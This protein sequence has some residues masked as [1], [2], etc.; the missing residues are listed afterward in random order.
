MLTA[1]S[2]E[3]LRPE[4]AQVG[5]TPDGEFRVSDLLVP[6]DGAGRQAYLVKSYSEAAKVGSHF[7]LVPQFQVFVE[8]EGTFQ[9]HAIDVP[10]VH[11][12]DAYTTYGPIVAGPA[13]LS[14]FV[15]RKDRD[16]PAHY[17][18]GSREALVRRGRRNVSAPLPDPGPDGVAPVWDDEDGLAAV[19]VDLAE[20]APLHGISATVGDGTYVL[21]LAGSLL[22]GGEPL[23]ER[24]CV[25][26]DREDD[27]SEVLGG[28]GGSRALVM[29][30]PHPPTEGDDQ[31]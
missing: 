31:T 28:P 16:G 7:H 23:A 13:G 8:G 2:A 18:P 17:M 5:T 11:Y 24:S 14:F 1:S 26:L 3:L 19:V 9:R 15:L 25:F 6:V 30:F 29:R 12:T 27:A 22:V 10:T 21:V 4:L 20:G